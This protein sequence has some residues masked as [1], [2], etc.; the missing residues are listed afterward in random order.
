MKR[1]YEKPSIDVDVLELDMPI[2]S[3]CNADKEDLES[4]MELGY[5]T[6]DMGCKKY[7][8]TYINPPN[9]DEDSVC[10]HSNV[11]TAFFS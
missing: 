2:A 3:G 6:Q 4:V 10:Y 1:V 5:F 11:Q 7:N 8:D 9:G